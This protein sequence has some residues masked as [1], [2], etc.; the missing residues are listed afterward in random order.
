MKGILVGLAIVAMVVCFGGDCFA[1][2]QGGC[3]VAT[4]ATGQLVRAEE[5]IPRPEL[6]R[7]MQA[8]QS[9]MWDLSGIRSVRF[10]ETPD[11]RQKQDTKTA[12]K[13][14]A[15][16]TPKSAGGQTKL[17]ISKVDLL[18]R[19]AAKGPAKLNIKR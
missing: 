15:K 1:Q 17:R 12:I 18:K 9:G 19:Y 2:C 3:N 11:I 14:T 4:R 5:A 7:L 6:Q 13:E 10:S 8:D 16:V